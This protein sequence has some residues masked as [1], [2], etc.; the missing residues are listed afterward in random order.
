MPASILAACSPSGIVT[1]LP[2]AIHARLENEDPLDE[3]GVS[4][5]ITP[6]VGL[7]VQ[8]IAASVFQLGCAGVV[9]FSDDK[10]AVDIYLTQWPE[11]ASGYRWTVDVE[12][13]P[14][15]S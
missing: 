15:P 3:T 12:A 2:T 6:S 7:A 10:R 8:V 1:S 11:L 4:M 5:T 13:E 14:P 9:R